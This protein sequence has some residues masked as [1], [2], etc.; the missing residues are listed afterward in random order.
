MSK[1]EGAKWKPVELRASI[2]VGFHFALR[3]SELEQLEDRDIS[4]QE[5]DGVRRI[6]VLIRGSE[7]DQQIKG[8]ERTLIATKCDLCP[9]ATMAEWMDMK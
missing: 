9:V 3:I 7:T 6:T 5:K 2:L 8:V 1:Y 4:V